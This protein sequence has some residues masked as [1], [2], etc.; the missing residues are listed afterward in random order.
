MTVSATAE[1][2]AIEM[3]PVVGILLVVAAIA[4]AFLLGRRRRR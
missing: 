1:L 4:G 2:G 3:P